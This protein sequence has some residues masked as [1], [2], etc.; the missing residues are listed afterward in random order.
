[1]ESKLASEVVC[2]KLWK[3]IEAG[4]CLVGI[5]LLRSVRIFLWAT[6]GRRTNETLPGLATKSEVISPEKRLVS[7]TKPK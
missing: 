2:N 1:M 5:E 3:G 6:L 4:R 7:P